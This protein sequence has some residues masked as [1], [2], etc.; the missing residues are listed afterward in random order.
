LKTKDC[1]EL[2]QLADE[3]GVFTDESRYDL[4]TMTAVLNAARGFAITELH[5]QNN[6]IHPSFLQRV[7]PEYKKELQQD[8]CYTLFE[9]PKTVGINNQIDGLMYVG[10]IDGKNSFWKIRTRMQANSRRNHRIHSIAMDKHVHFLYDNTRGYLEVYDDKVKYI[11]VEGIFGD[12]TSIPGFNLEEDDYPI[13]MDAMKR[14]EDMVRTGTIRD[15]VRVPIN[16]ISNSAED[17]NVQRDIK[18]K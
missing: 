18:V 5:K 8:D 12:P 17:S 14:I 2:I 1:I 16:K 11:L 6:R 9:V 3:G 13:T 10:T 4:G 15:V 7:Y